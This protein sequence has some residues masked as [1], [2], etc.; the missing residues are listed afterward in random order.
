MSDD[1]EHEV[2]TSTA[3]TAKATSAVA[4]N[5]SSF[6]SFSDLGA[7]IPASEGEDN[8]GNGRGSATGS[9]LSFSGLRSL[10]HPNSHTIESRFNESSPLLQSQQRRLQQ[11]SNKKRRRKRYVGGIEGLAAY[12]ATSYESEIIGEPSLAVC[13]DCEAKETPISAV[14]LVII[15][16]FLFAM[17][18]LLSEVLARDDGGE[19]HRMSELQILS[20]QATS[21]WITSIVTL[22]STK[23]EYA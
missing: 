15:S 4:V 11:L 7:A 18:S 22:L 14:K 19:G 8:G 5:E 13:R 10:L 20:I 16:Q 6:T 9:V 17:M 21:L 12:D 2:S 1:T 3:A 23:T